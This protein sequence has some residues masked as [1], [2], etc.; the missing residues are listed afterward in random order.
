MAELPLNRCD[1]AGFLYEVPPHSMAG[2][3]GCVA[4]YPARAHKL[5]SR[6]Y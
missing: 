5:H 1:I 6:S 2:I 4:P 3:M